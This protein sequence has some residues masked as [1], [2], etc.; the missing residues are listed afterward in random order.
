MEHYLVVSDPQEESISVDNPRKDKT[1]VFVVINYF[2]IRG[3][4]AV[5]EIQDFTF[6]TSVDTAELGKRF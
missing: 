1:E 6:S 5:H 2:Y 4:L 3:T